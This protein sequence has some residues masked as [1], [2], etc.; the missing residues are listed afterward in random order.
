MAVICARFWCLIQWGEE[1]ACIMQH[2]AAQNYIFDRILTESS[3][4]ILFWPTLWSKFRSKFNILTEKTQSKCRSKLY[5]DRYFR[6]KLPSKFILTEISVKK[7][8]NIFWPI[9]QK[10]ISTNV[11]PTDRF[12]S[13]FQSKCPISVKILCFFGQNFGQN[14]LLIL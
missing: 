5:F 3:V 6:S 13:K 11:F 4:K 7:S 2:Y 8:V 9:G 12:R 10:I 14:Q 1:H